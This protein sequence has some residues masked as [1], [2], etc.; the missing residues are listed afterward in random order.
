MFVVYLL[1]FKLSSRV[2]QL[3]QQEEGNSQRKNAYKK[4]EMAFKNH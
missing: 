1:M 4:K 3:H 2:S